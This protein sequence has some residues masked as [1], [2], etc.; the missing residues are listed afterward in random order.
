MIAFE[1]VFM[2]N[3]SVIIQIVFERSDIDF[4][5]IDHEGHSFWDYTE[6]DKE[7]TIMNFM[8]EKIPLE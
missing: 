1:A 5:R 2:R 4:V 3:D 6:C 8:C 7:S